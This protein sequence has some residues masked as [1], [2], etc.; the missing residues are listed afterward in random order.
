MTATIPGQRTGVRVELA[1]YTVPAGE[2]VLYGQR[3]DG[4]ACFLPEEPV[5]LDSALGSNEGSG[6]CP[7]EPLQEDGSPSTARHKRATTMAGKRRQPT[8]RRSGA[9]APAPAWSWRGT[10]YLPVIECYM[11]S[12]LTGW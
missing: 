7:R 8:L 1:R 11:A 6:C 5:V 3:F 4:V 10:R 12:G 9:V 2:R